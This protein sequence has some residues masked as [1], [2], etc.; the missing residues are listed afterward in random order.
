MMSVL[1]LGTGKERTSTGRP[2]A[3]EGNPMEREEVRV[4]DRES[5]H[6]NGK[7]TPS[8][9]MGWEEREGGGGRAG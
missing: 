7:A 9:V 3:P 6:L 4:G 2:H 5:T 1:E 8:S